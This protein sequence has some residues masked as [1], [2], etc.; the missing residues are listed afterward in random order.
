[1][2]EADV[3]RALAERRR[4]TPRARCECEYSSRKWCSTSHTYVEAELVGELDLVERVL[5]E[6]RAR[7]RRPTGGAAGARRR[8]RTSSRPP[9]VLGAVPVAGRGT[10]RGGR[11]RRRALPSHA[12]LDLAERSAWRVL[13]RP[14]PSDCS[15]AASQSVPIISVPSWLRPAVADP[16]AVA[17]L[18]ERGL[19]V[20]D[21]RRLVG[22]DVARRASAASPSPATRSVSDSH[23]SAQAKVWNAEISMNSRRIMQLDA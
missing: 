10:R 3:L 18:G 8:C 9:A 21:V 19:Q 5:D 1:M 14:A 2:A 4:G 16:G 7:C 6:L 11:R 22:A 20:G 23:A 12:V 13:A 15:S 17:H